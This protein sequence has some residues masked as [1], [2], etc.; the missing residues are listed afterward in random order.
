MSLLLKALKQAE[1]TQ[2]QPATD[3]PGT[4]ATIPEL[5]LIEPTFATH[6]DWVQPSAAA[7]Q[8]NR[9]GRLGG[10]RLP[11]IG[12]VPAA[13]LIALIVALGYGVYVY[14]AISQPTF[15]APSPRQAIAPITALNNPAQP[16]SGPARNA[17]PVRPASAASPNLSVTRPET[18]KPEPKRAVP[19]GHA[20]HTH[21]ANPS[22]HPATPPDKPAPSTP[23]MEEIHS[24]PPLATLDAAYQ[25]YQAGHLNEARALYEKVPNR[26]RNTDALLGLAAIAMAQG[27]NPDGVQLYQRVIA[28]DPHNTTAQAA[29]IDALGTVDN[30]AAE[31]RLKSQI[32]QLPNA[33][34]YYALG[35]LYAGQNRWSEAEPAYFE[36]SKREPSNGDY[37]FN[38][39]ISLDHL[40]Q[41]DAALKQ[42][43][44][45]LNLAGPGTRFDHNLA[46]ARIRQLKGR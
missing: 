11:Q 7:E 10:I 34:L 3:P 1:Q 24:D 37:A 43:E 41:Y 13:A 46:E 22:E 6:S 12:L 33:Y 28:L 27:R 25:A 44:S 38:L 8:Q 19:S 5:E 45:A 15:L 29:L 42:Y 40:R 4:D 17:A 30:T 23:A 32:E 26:N 9:S 18:R 39:A 36:A 16:A 35:N 2:H 14:L 31:A 21:H 20:R